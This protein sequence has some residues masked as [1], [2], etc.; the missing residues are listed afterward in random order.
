MASD[1]EA[2]VIHEAFTLFN[3]EVWGEMTDEQ[4]EVFDADLTEIFNDTVPQS[5][6]STY[7]G[8]AVSILRLAREAVASQERTPLWDGVLGLYF[9]M[10]L[11]Q[12]NCRN[13]V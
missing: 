5:H 6:C 9:S 11:L 7:A 10:D 13:E 1:I 8:T 4:F 2:D 12:F 3:D